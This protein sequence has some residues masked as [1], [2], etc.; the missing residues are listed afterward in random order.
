VTPRVALR[1]LIGVGALVLSESFA[2]GARAQNPPTPVVPLP[3]ATVSGVVVDSAGIPIP[4]AVFSVVGESLRVI[5]DSQGRFR[6]TVPPGPRLVAVRALG[7]R[8]LMWAV[9]LGSGLEASGRIRLQRLSIVLPE[10]TVVGERYV[11]RR[12]ADFY[13]R[14]RIGLGKYIDPETIAGRF[15][16]SMADL[17]QQIPGVRVSPVPGDPFNYLV[18][19]ARC[20]LIGSPGG[21]PAGGALTPGHLGQSTS[22]LPSGPPRKSTVGVYMDGFKVPGDPGEIL[23]M[24]NPA[25]VEAIEVYRGPAELPAEFMSDDCAAIVIW[26]KY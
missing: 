26:T 10:M 5:T 7:Y 8:P 4:R 3:P 6:L 11:P 24:I 23:A 1:V 20:N 15:T 16:N 17:L 13:Q 14:R 25:D 19:F 22:P 9:T 2:W 21:A 18:S 12:L